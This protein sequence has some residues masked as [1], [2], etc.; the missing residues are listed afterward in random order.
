VA[1]ATIEPDRAVFERLME[2]FATRYAD[3]WGKWGPRFR[4]GWDDGSRVMIR[5]TPIGA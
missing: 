4:K 3:E 5:Y 1:R 2:R